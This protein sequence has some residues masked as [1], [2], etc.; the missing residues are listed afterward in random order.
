MAKARKSRFY[1][2]EFEKSPL[3]EYRNGNICPVKNCD[4][5]QL[6]QKGDLVTLKVFVRKN[7]T[8]SPKVRGIVARMS[9]NHVPL[10]AVCKEHSKG[11]A[12][13][14]VLSGGEYKRCIL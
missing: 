14:W 8:R 7:A 12:T 10:K 2:N 11:H 9:R 5:A 3:E 6:I 13:V 4:Q 1:Y